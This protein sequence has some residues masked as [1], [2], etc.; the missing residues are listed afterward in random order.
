VDALELGRDRYHVKQAKAQVRQAEHA[1]EAL[2]DGISVEVTADVLNVTEA[3]EKI[4]VAQTGARFA[5]ES[6]RST[7]EKFKNGLAPNSDVLDAENE[8][9]KA[10]WNQTQALVD[11]EVAT[12]KLAKSTG[13]Q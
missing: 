6:F 10:R 4:A 7:R 1:L 3:K 12:A 11:Y 13:Q 9:L 5:E 2:K 8:L